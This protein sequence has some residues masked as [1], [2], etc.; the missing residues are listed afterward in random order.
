[1]D[2]LGGGSLSFSDDE[3]SSLERDEG[4][5]ISFATLTIP[6]EHSH[7]LYSNGIFLFHVRKGYVANRIQSNRPAERKFMKWVFMIVGLLFLWVCVFTCERMITGLPPV[8]GVRLSS[9]T[10]NLQHPGNPDFVPPAISSP[11]LPPVVAH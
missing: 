6:A 11:P 5:K 7:W 3:E 4:F 10:V 8:G 1:M 9:I 2:L